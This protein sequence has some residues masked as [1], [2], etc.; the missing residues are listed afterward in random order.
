[1]KRVKKI[2]IMFHLMG[3]GKKGGNRSKKGEESMKWTAKK[4]RS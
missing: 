2:H 1:L 4:E 3:S